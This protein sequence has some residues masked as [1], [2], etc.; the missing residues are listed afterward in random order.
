MVLMKFVL[1]ASAFINASALDVNEGDSYYTVSDVEEEIKDASSKGL[2]ERLKASKALVFLSPSKEAIKIVE[3]AASRLGSIRHLSNTDI[4]VLALALDLKATLISDDFTMQNV[5]MD[6]GISFE[7]VL[8]GK[9][10]EKKRFRK[11]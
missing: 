5:A 8:R 9:I 6:L 11:I 4:K 1:D 10:K 2:L 3:K 7:A